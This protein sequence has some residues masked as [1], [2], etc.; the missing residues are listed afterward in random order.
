MKKQTCSSCGYH[1]NFAELL[2]IIA[3]EIIRIYKNP[4]SIS[5]ISNII[6]LKC[7]KCSKR[8]AWF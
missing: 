2:L 7:P 1:M 3:I 5:L 4:I 6:G 8:A